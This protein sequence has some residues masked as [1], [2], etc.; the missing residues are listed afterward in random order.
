MDRKSASQSL[1]SVVDTFGRFRN[2]IYSQDSETHTFNVFK[3]FVT[4]VIG[5]RT[6]RVGLRV[7]ARTEGS[8]YFYNIMRGG[9]S[10]AIN[11]AAAFS[12]DKNLDGSLPKPKT[13]LFGKKK[14]KM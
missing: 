10:N 7:H 2:K 8:E 11:S 13:N 5:S 14:K 12:H 4:K 9:K 6:R 3:Y 1:D